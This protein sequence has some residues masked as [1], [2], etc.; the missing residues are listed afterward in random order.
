MLSNCSVKRCRDGALPIR[1]PL[2]SCII[3]TL[4]A[5]FLACHPYIFLHFY[6]FYFYFYFL[7]FP[8]QVCVYDKTV[9][10]LCSICLETQPCWLATWYPGKSDDFVQCVARVCCWGTPV[11]IGRNWQSFQLRSPYHWGSW[12]WYIISHMWC[13]DWR[14]RD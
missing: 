12:T 9:S 2:L 6:C 7:V 14:S 13:Q 1:W 11:P 8:K 10:N 5:Y 4:F 3:R